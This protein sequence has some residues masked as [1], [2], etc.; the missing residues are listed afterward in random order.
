MEI[1]SAHYPNERLIACR[2]T[3]LARE[4]QKNREELLK[5]TEEAFSSA[6]AVRVASGRHQ[7]K[8]ERE[9]ALE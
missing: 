2:N 8:I 7:D 4:R 6:L 3:Y 9:A 1:R 5:K